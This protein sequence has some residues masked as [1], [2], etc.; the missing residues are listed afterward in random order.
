MDGCRAAPADV[1]DQHLE[2]A[3][4][5]IMLRRRRSRSGGYV[6]GQPDSQLRLNGS[7]G[8]CFMPPPDAAWLY[9]H[10]AWLLLMGPPSQAAV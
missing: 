3:L 5:G 4:K 2:G 1:R 7:T 10:A 9:L 6:R 8:L